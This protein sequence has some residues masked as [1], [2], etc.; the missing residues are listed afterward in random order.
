MQTDKTMTIGVENETKVW[1]SVK[2]LVRQQLKRY[3]TTIEEDEEILKRNSLE[4]SLSGNAVN[5]ITF[6]FGEKE[7]LRFL[8]KAATQFIQVLKEDSYSEKEFEPLSVDE[9]Y[10]E[11]VITILLPLMEGAKDDD[12]FKSF[13]DEDQEKSTEPVDV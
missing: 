3:E 1:Q 4:S 5:C 13:D 11:Y 9:K 6:R 10:Q 8:D 2:E 7:V 12:S